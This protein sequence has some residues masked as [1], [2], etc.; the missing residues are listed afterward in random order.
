MS[1]ARMVLVG[2]TGLVGRTLIARSAA[3]RPGFRLAALARRRIDLPRGARMEMFVSEPAFWAETI[4]ALKPEIVINAL[5][6]TWKK[7]GKSEEAFRAVDHDLVIAVGRA[8]KEAGTRH[9]IHI[10]SAGASRMSRHLYLRVKGE[11]EEDLA[12]LRFNRLDI[13]RPGLLRGRRL[14]DTRPAEALMQAASPLSDI[15][16]QGQYRRYRS[17]SADRLVDTIYGLARERAGGR[18]IHEHDALLRA[19]RRHL[20]SG[21]INLT[22]EV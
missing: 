11:T 9:F 14:D 13:L 20:G 19:A 6:T 15:F 5:G 1:D 22:F 10:S 21:P 3:D 12:R 4:A 17:I 16:L 7:S 2:A 8:A 18:F